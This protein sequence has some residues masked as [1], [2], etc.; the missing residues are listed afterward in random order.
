MCLRRSACYHFE[1]QPERSHSAFSALFLLAPFLLDLYRKESRCGHLDSFYTTTCLPPKTRHLSV[2]G[3][4]A[5]VPPP[6]FACTLHL[7]FEGEMAVFNFDPAPVVLPN[8]AIKLQRNCFARWAFDDRVRTS[9]RHFE[10]A[11]FVCSRVFSRGIRCTY[12]RNLS[13]R[14]YLIE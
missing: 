7:I 2:A 8:G 12:F 13:R 10:F 5:V 1:N 11:G 3:A 6:K 4:R 9:V 14:Y